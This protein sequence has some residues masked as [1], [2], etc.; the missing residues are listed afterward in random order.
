[1][2]SQRYS[3]APSRTIVAPS[4]HRDDVVLG[5]AHRELAQAV[6]GG[7]L[8]QGGEPGAAR[9]GVVTSG[10]IVIRPATGNGERSR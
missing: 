6:G 3:A 7:E 8:A 2:V 10:G 1:M 5:G 4:S 9:L